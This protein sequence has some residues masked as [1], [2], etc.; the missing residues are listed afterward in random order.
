MSVSPIS[1]SSL[2]GLQMTPTNKLVDRPGFAD[3]LKATLNT[4]NTLQHQS[5]NAQQELATGR[6]GNI[7]ETFIAM[8]KATVSFRMVMQ[9]RNKMIS[10]Y[11]EI[12]RMQ[13]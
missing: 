7:H 10:A 5:S 4:A 3:H 2:P 12:M 9:V 13:V 8:N 1:T 11:Q 6:S